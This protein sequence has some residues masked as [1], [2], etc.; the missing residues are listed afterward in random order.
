[1]YL[2]V[3]LDRNQLDGADSKQIA[4]DLDVPVEKVNDECQNLENK[5]FAHID[6]RNMEH[7][8]PKDVFAHIT[9]EG[10]EYLS[11]EHGIPL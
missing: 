6:K 7:G 11:K 3:A 2:K 8:K 10:I 1:M 9:P 5:H 4:A